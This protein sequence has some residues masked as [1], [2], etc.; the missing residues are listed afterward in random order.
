LSVNYVGFEEPRG[1]CHSCDCRV[2]RS[3]GPEAM[4]RV[5]ACDAVF[6]VCEMDGRLVAVVRGDYDGS[7]PV[8][9]QLS[10]HPEY[11]TRGIGTA[12]VEEIV[13]RFQRMAAPTSAR[14]DSM[15][16]LIL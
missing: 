5:K 7:R 16:C 1:P 9:H 14:P 15:K 8:I 2:L 3:D 11:Q 12:L 13:K 10:V 6:L 4:R